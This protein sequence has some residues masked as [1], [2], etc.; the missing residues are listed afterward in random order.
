MPRSTEIFE[1][2]YIMRSCEQRYENERSRLLGS[3]AL[4]KILKTAS[5][6]NDLHQEYIGGKSIIEENG[7]ITRQPD[8]SSET[9]ALTS[10]MV[11]KPYSSGDAEKQMN[12]RLS[13]GIINGRELG[14]SLLGKYGK[15]YPDLSEVYS[16]IKK[17]PLLSIG[18]EYMCTDI[19]AVNLLTRKGTILIDKTNLEKVK[20]Y[21]TA[22]LTILIQEMGG[23]FSNNYPL[24]A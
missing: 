9:I 4:L 12:L 13:V 5:I 18:G 6:L 24:V 1:N 7:V 16:E 14:C 19:P 8:F 23:V 10:L 3:S 15:D 11:E 21:T 20:Q 17:N 2:S 22:K